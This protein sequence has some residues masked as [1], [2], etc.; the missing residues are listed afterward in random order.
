MAVPGLRSLAGQAGCHASAPRP[1]VRDG[2]RTAAPGGQAVCAGTALAVLAPAAGEH[3]GLRGDTAQVPDAQHGQ[4]QHQAG[5]DERADGGDPGDRAHGVE[6]VGVEQQ[7]AQR[8]TA[9][10]GLHLGGQRRV[11]GVG[12]RCLDSWA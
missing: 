3:L 6:G 7:A 11:L 12:Q 2:G 5:A 9:E 10:H 8:L 4:D 1:V